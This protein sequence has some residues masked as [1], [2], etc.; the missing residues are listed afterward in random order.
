MLSADRRMRAEREELTY[1]RTAPN[2][3]SQVSP[4]LKQ[5]TEDPFQANKQHERDRE[6][7]QPSTNNTAFLFTKQLLKPAI[8][9]FV[10]AVAKINLKM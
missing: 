4:E 7:R 10:F 2:T 6:T 5:G 8:L 3:S 9:N 1:C